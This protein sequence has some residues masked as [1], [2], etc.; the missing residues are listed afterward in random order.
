LEDERNKTCSED[1]YEKVLLLQKLTL[2][3]TSKKTNKQTNKQKQNNN[4]HHF[5][6]KGLNLFPGLPLSTQRALQYQTTFVG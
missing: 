6:A 4:L 5:C 1:L 2:E 3:L